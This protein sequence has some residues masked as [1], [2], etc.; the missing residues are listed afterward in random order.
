[1]HYQLLAV[2][3]DK[4]GTENLNWQTE[5]REIWGRV[6]SCSLLNGWINVNIIC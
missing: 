2:N 4:T 5:M 3:I 6:I 1:M